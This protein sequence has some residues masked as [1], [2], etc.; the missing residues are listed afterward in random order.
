MKY[1][2]NS[3]RKLLFSVIPIAARF[4]EDPLMFN[5]DSTGTSYHTYLNSMDRI[6]VFISE[7]APAAGSSWFHIL[8]LSTNNFFLAILLIDIFFI[9]FNFEIV[10]LYLLFLDWIF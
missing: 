10:L 2:L 4:L 5:K 6:L 3:L 7:A 9:N 8:D 1:L